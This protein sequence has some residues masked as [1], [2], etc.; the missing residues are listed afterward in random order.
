MAVAGQWQ[1]TR[2]TGSSDGVLACN[3]AEMVGGNA[4]SED[5]D[6]LAAMCWMCLRVLLT[7]V[8]EM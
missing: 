2:L 6:G 3:V 1:P 7:V 4:G 5:A 8:S